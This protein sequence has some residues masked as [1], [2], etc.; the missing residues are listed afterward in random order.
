MH[1][2]NRVGLSFGR[3][4]RAA[5]IAALFLLLVLAAG[6]SATPTE[7]PPAD[8]PTATHTAQPDLAEPPETA[9]SPP[10]TPTTQPSD[11][12]TREPAATDTPLPPTPT[13]TETPTPEASARYELTFEATWSSETHPDDFPPNPHFSGLIGAVHGP[14]TKLWAAGGLA[15]PGMRSM[16]ET[17]S[18]RP[19]NS[20]IAGLIDSG[21]AC[22]LISGDG[23]ARSPGSASVVFTAE[24]ACSRVSVVTMIAPSPDWFVGVAGLDLIE[25]G[26]WT[27]QIELDLVPWDAGSDSG[28]AYRS[29]NSPTDPQGPI[30]TIASAPFLNGGDV[31]PL[32]TFTITRLPDTE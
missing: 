29:S 8:E 32:G 12:S 1:A 13:A 21:G 2:D 15:S 3:I 6:C 18:K 22:E 11:T 24:L 10:S 9:T 14:D 23:I 27:D 7:V 28:P 25:N 4:A 16:A 30:S 26:V 31:V 17:G 20:E 5:E 19:L